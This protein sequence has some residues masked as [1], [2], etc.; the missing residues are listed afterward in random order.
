MKSLENFFV[1]NCVALVLSPTISGIPFCSDLLWLAITIQVPYDF[2]MLL[3]LMLD[4]PR[5]SNRQPFRYV[6]LLVIYIPASYSHKMCQEAKK[7]IKKGFDEC[8]DIRIR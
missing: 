4:P 2:T 6:V 3:L 5:L 1:T 7:I 8:Y